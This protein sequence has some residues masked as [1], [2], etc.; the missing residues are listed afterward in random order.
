MELN[1]DEQAW[2]DEYRQAL[3]E[4]YP[5][6]V[7]EMVIFRDDEALSYVPDYAI[8]TVVVLKECDRQTRKAVER[9]GYH[10]AG[11]SDAW[12]IIWAYNHSEWKWRGQKGVLPYL[13][14]GTSVWS[15]NP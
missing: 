13:G 1:A 8:N 3:Q 10:V 2:L 11:L 12:P 15:R 4:N 6:L 9:L 14:D 5:G 7:D